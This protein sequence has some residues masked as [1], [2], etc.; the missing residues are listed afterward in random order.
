MH[1]ASLYARDLGVKIGK[2][3]LVPHFFPVLD[4]KYIVIHNGEKVPA[5]NYSYWKDVIDIIKPQLKKEGIKIYQIGLQQEKTIEGIDRRI[6]TNSLKQSSFVIKNSLLV[7]GIDSVPIHLASCLDIPSVS[8]YAHTYANTCSPLW[9]EK[10]KAIIIE[11]ER[12]GQKPSFSLEEDPKTIDLIYPEVIAEEI[13][14]Q[15]NIQ[16]TV[17]RKT[18]FIGGRYNDKCIDIIPAAFVSGLPDKVTIRMDI[19]HDE[20]LLNN[21]LQY[22]KGRYLIKTDKPINIDILNNNKSKIESVLYVSGEFEEDFINKMLKS[23]LDFSLVC[24]DPKKLKDQRLKFF[25]FNVHYYN[26]KE[27]I[28]VQK[29]KIKKKIKGK[30]QYN[31]NKIYF[32]GT[33]KFAS[34]LDFYRKIGKNVSEDAFYLDSD[35]MMIYTE[36]RV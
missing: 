3:I 11:S 36:S 30:V 9:N 34:L 13:F 25:E 32:C 24:G 21:I 4:E 17:R 10:S 31:T 6:L 5:K 19:H 1:L 27:F 16:Q 29:E 35:H 8:I 26:E 28:Q 33:E 2:P 7:A 12:N 18:I 14:H 22:N 20:D 23:G 15:L